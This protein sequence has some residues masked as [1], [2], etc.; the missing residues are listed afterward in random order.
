VHIGLSLQ[1]Q[2][3]S[4]YKGPADYP[5]ETHS[6]LIVELGKRSYVPFLRTESRST[7]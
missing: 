4:Y 2:K 1:N 3:H 6:L 7:P 5:N